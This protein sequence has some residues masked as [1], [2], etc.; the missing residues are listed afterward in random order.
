MKE[1]PTWRSE[2]KCPPPPQPLRARALT[3]GQCLYKENG[4]TAEAAPT[5]VH[6]LAGSQGLNCEL[7]TFTHQLSQALLGSAHTGQQYCGSP[8]YYDRSFALESARTYM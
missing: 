2:T 7:A 4:A 8:A 1:T 6:S 5:S 3:S